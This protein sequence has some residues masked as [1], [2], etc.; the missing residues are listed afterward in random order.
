MDPQVLAGY[1]RH[2]GRE[3]LDGRQDLI[4]LPVAGFE[5][6]LR[7]FE[8]SLGARPLRP[9]QETRSREGVSRLRAEGGGGGEDR[10]F[11]GAAA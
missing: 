7:A 8:G 3:D 1:L 5:D 11:R 6:R 9:D 4:R 10:T 2:L